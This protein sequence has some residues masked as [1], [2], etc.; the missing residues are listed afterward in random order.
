MKLEL[1]IGIYSGDDLVST[2]NYVVP[3]EPL[4]RVFNELPEDAVISI[5][6]EG[7]KELYD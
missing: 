6:I 7:L 1:S 4:A 3:V 2:V 5:D